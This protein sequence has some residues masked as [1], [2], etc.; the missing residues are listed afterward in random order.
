MIQADISVLHY[1]NCFRITNATVRENIIFGHRFDPEF[2]QKTIRACAL[3]DDFDALPDG[4]ET[5][6]GEK[7]ISLSGKYIPVISNI[8]VL[9]VCRRPEGSRESREGCV[10]P[11]GCI[12]S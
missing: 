8:P 11:S 1:A 3:L 4:D 10:R 12:H 7:G 2:Y 6:V 5:E 9:T